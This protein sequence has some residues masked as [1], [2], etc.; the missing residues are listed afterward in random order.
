[1]REALGPEMEQS[2]DK[3]GDLERNKLHGF[4]KK[5]TATQQCDSSG[6]NSRLSRHLH[7]KAAVKTATAVVAPTN[8]LIGKGWGDYRT[9]P[10]S[11]CCRHIQRVG[12]V[13]SSEGYFTG[14]HNIIKSEGKGKAKPHLLCPSWH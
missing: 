13:D 4:I 2:L 6:Q 8:S 7:L 11:R 5:H 9:T 12:G 14:H 1:M 3:H 10:Y